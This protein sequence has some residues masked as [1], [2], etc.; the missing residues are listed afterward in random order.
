MWQTYNCS[1]LLIYRP[2]MD[3]R[4]SWPGWLTY[5]GRFTHISG[6]PSTVGRAQDRK[7]SPSNTDVLPLCHATIF[8]PIWPIINR[9]HMWAVAD[10]LRKFHA[11]FSRNH[12]NKQTNRYR[13]LKTKYRRL[14]TGTS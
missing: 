14:F 2:R 5:S 4:L 6:Y 1:L 3:E 8:Y 11:P 12:S 10:L 7:S 13:G 9:H